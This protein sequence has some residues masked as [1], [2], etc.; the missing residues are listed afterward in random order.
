M[1]NL[2]EK[3][4]K[5]KKMINRISSITAGAAM[6][7]MLYTTNVYASG[8]EVVTAP[9]NNLKNLVI[10]IIGAVGVIILA[11]NVM[12]FAQSYQQDSSSMNSAIKG[13]VA[14]LIMAGIS[15]VL[16]FLGIS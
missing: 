6:A 13:I 3:K 12:E 11:K 4:K 15:T 10:A 5:A 1:K 14:G 8:A 16:T 2:T 7:T 9:L